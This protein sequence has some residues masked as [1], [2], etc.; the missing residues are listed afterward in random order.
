MYVC[1]HVSMYVCMKS[2]NKSY[3]A[4][5]GGRVAIRSS[6]FRSVVKKKGCMVRPYRFE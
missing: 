4:G 3:L 2:E 6:I 5:M 1:M